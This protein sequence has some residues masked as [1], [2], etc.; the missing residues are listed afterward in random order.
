MAGTTA[1][2]AARRHG[3][4]SARVRDRVLAAALDEL[5]EVGYGRLSFESVANRAGVHKTTVYRRW[6][7]R[8]ALVTAA[9]LAQRARDVP[10]PDTG[11]IRSDLR[12]L[13][14]AI[15][16]SITSPTGQAVVRSLVSEAGDIAEVTTA[17]RDFWTA[18]FAVARV[19]VSRAVDRGELAPGIDPDFLIEAL[20]GP[21][22]LRLLV[23][24]GP[25]DDAFIG[26]L[27]DLLLSGAANPLAV[28]P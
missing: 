8:E 18:R 16:A 25:L 1:P 11:S 10:I 24:R 22:Y 23:T 3:G 20:V 12:I 2:A 6:P 14:Q 19:V 28:R 4:R 26:K 17:V 21:L 9:L 15:A 27:V 5:L 7:S 13:A